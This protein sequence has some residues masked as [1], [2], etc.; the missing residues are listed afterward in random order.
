MALPILKI[1]DECNR[2]AN[3]YREKWRA[4][5]QNAMMIEE[6]LPNISYKQGIRELDPPFLL[7][8]PSSVHMSILN[9]VNS[10]NPKVAAKVLINLSD[11]LNPKLEVFLPTLDVGVSTICW[12]GFTTT[13][14]SVIIHE[15]LH[16]CGDIETPFNKIRDGLIRHTWIG[17]EA[18]TNLIDNVTGY[19]IT[20][21]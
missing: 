7:T 8:S 12:I 17:T 6:G 18:I 13:F 16:L 2:V 3:L 19:S 15:F 5:D 10:P 14:Q 1:Q 9:L 4:K 21:S 11:Y 20:S